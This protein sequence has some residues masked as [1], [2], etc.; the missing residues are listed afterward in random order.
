MKYKVGDKVRIRKDL[1][2]GEIYG[3]CCVTP[4]LAVTGQMKCLR[5]YGI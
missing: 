3:T 2:V 5:R 1:K 4:D